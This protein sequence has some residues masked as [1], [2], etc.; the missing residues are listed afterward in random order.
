MPLVPYVPKKLHELNLG[1]GEQVTSPTVESTGHQYNG[2]ASHPFFNNP[3]RI[4]AHM[5]AGKTIANNSN[6]LL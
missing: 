1:S 4:N 3:M 2:A 5:I 6:N